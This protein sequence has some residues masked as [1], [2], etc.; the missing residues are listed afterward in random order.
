MSW[1]P[2]AIV[3][4][5]WSGPRFVHVLEDERARNPHHRPAGPRK[6][7]PWTLITPQN[8]AR[9]RRARNCWPLL[10]AESVNGRAAS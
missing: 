4:P 10:T 5:A 2:Q 6:W 3:I 9:M 8:E 1:F 7:K